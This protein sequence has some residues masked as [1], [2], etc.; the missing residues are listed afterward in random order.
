MKNDR[1]AARSCSN[2]SSAVLPYCWIEIYI[3]LRKYCIFNLHVE[4]SLRSRQYSTP[5]SAHKPIFKESRGA[6]P[7]PASMRT[8]RGGGIVVE[9]LS[10]VHSPAALQEHETV[11]TRLAVSFRE[12][13]LSESS[14]IRTLL[15]VLKRIYCEHK[16][17]Q[18][19]R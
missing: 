13:C 7:G 19:N 15:T 4:R 9:S 11:I 17:W 10:G 5:S 6:L 3:N 18:T 16:V 8:S 2:C 12:N 1:V 14:E